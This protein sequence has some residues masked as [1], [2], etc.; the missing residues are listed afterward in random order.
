MLRT[1]TP[2]EVERVDDLLGH[3]DPD[4]LQDFDALRVLARI[5]FGDNSPPGGQRSKRQNC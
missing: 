1:I 4:L 2:A 3:T 5:E